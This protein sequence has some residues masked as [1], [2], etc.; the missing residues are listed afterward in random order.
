MFVLIF[1]IDHFIEYYRILE[2]LGPVGPQLLVGGPSGQLFALWVS[3][4]S[5]FAPFGR[6]GRVT[7]ASITITI[8][9]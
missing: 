4:T 3:S 7:R 5:S 2:V 6:S 9:W 1:F 8:F